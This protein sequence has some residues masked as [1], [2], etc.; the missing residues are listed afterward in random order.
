MSDQPEPQQV[1]LEVNIAW[2]QNTYVDAEPANAFV[3][4]DLGENMCFAF[5]FV[6]PP[7]AI[8]EAAKQGPLTIEVEKRRAFVLPKGMVLSLLQSLQQTIAKNPHMFGLSDNGQ[9]GIVQEDQ[10]ANKA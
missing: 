1:E 9:F 7:P 5:G 4:T 10:N 8:E 3:F 2:P 6:P